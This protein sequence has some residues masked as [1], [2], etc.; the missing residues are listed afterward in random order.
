MTDKSLQ[1]REN[2]AKV[3]SQS[4]KLQVV[5]YLPDGGL[6]GQRYLLGANSSRR[7]CQLKATLLAGYNAFHYRLL[8]GINTPWFEED[9]PDAKRN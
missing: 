8:A 6:L 4:N 3:S 2:N 1:K 5:N 7:R 9:V